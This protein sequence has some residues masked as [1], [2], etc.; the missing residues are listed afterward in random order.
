MLLRKNIRSQLKDVIMIVIGNIVM[1]FGYAEFMVPNR[2]INGGVTSLA[3]IVNHFAPLDIPMANNFL[4]GGLL[5]LALIF[6]GKEVFAKSLLSSII[7]SLFFTLFYNLHWELVINP[8]ID[9]LIASILISF[10]YFACLSS[11]SSTVGVD[12]LALIIKKFRPQVNLSYT[13]RQLNCIVLILGLVSF[14]ILPVVYGIGF[15]FI[16]SAE[17][18]YMLEHFNK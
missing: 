3:Q 12:V 15:T 7:Y 4:L 8:L 5:V 17:L 13:I 1:A 18:K 10:G 6:L 16:Y 2:F 9:L 11:N 14:G